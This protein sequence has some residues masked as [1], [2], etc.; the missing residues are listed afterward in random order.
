MPQVINHLPY[1]VSKESDITTYPI[2][3]NVQ[4]KM[5]DSVCQVKMLRNLPEII[6]FCRQKTIAKKRALGHIMVRVGWQN[7]LYQNIT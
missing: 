5:L 2:A 6:S 4:Q 7:H 1:L 3:K